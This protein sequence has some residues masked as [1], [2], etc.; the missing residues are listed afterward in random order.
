MIFLEVIAEKW[1]IICEKTGP[2]FRKVGHFFSVV[3]DYLKRFW[4]YLLRLRKI[5]MAV[6]VV[7]GA[8]V[9]A[10]RNLTQLPET[11][12]LNLQIDGTFAIQISREI[13]VLGPVALTALCLLLMFCSRRTLTPWVVSVISLVVPLFIWLINVFPS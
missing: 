2:G 7:W 9:L 5:F 13:A 3:G 6:P 8:V 1:R 10:M 12:G 11:V 4:R